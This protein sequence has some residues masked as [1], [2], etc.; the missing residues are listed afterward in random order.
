MKLAIRFHLHPNIKAIPIR[1]FGGALLKTRKGSG[2]QFTID[3]G[4][5]VIEDRVY[6][7]GLSKP[8]RSK[9]IVFYS[10]TESHE[11][12]VKWLLEKI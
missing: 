3:G 1:N 5:L 8:R 4:S 7:E 12:I 2:W 6:V 11:K 10:E 9:Q